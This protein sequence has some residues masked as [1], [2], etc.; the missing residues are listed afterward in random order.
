MKKQTYILSFIAISLI[1]AAFFLIPVLRKP[2]PEITAEYAAQIAVDNLGL[3]G[4]VS[5]K[6]FIGGH[7]GAQLFT[8]FSETKKYIVRFFGNI[9]QNKIKRAIKHMKSASNGKFGPHIYYAS[10][11]KGL[12]IMEYLTPKYPSYL[13]HLKALFKSNQSQKLY[14]SFGNLL[15]NMHQTL[16]TSKRRNV[17]DNIRIR[18]ETI[19]QSVNK[20]VP[21]EKLE[22]IVATIRKAILL[23]QDTAAC[24]NDLNSSNLIILENNRVKAIDYDDVAQG[25][26]YY[27]IAYVDVFFCLNP[28]NEQILLT[29]YLERQPTPL[30]KAKLYLMKQMA[31]ISDA[32]HHLKRNLKEIHLYK[33]IEAPLF[34]DLLKEGAEGKINLGNPIHILR[35]VKSMFNQVLLN[36][37][38]QEFKNSIKILHETPLKNSHKPWEN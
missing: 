30:E 2:A 36:A 16:K 14:V 27:D 12:V 13:Q 34:N 19:K 37:Q 4:P 35:I 21:I 26:P 32:L 28:T 31:W 9:S 18:L 3:S 6:R 23:Q 7:S 20:D 11:K 29:T 17:F 22:K 38:S 33:E 24:H 15:R 10:E 1:A 25:N 5:A 8:V